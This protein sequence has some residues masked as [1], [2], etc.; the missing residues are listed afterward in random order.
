MS[1]EYVTDELIC[2]IIG[3]IPHD[4]VILQVDGRIYS[5][6]ALI[7]WLNNNNTSPY[8]RKPC[9]IADIIKSPVLTNICAAIH[10]DTNNVVSTTNVDDTGPPHVTSHITSCGPVSLTVPGYRNDQLL[11]KLECT[12]NNNIVVGTKSLEWSDIILCIDNSYSTGNRVETH[13]PITGVAIESGYTINDLIRHTAKAVLASLENTGSRVGVI[14]FDDCVEEITHLTEVT[15]SNKNI[16]LAKIDEIAPRG[17]TNIWK[18][19]REAAK[20]LMTRN[21]NS[22][23]PAILLLTDGQPSHGTNRPENEAISNLFSSPPHEWNCE[24][25]GTIPVYSMGFGYS[26][27]HGL[28]YKIARDTGGVNTSIPGPEMMVTAF[29]S[30]LANILNT[31]CFSTKIHIVLHD[32]SLWNIGNNS[33]IIDA[34]LPIKY[35]YHDDNTVHIEILIGSLQFEQTRDIVLNIEPRSN[36]AIATLNASFYEGGTLSKT[37]NITICANDLL[38][39]TLN[40]EFEYHFLRNAACLSL[41]YMAEARERG[42]YHLCADHYERILALCALTPGES[43]YKLRLTWEDQVKMAA[44]YDTD[45]CCNHWNK[46]GWIYVDQ[47]RSALANQCSTNFKDEALLP[48]VTPIV[49]ETS[50][51]VSNIFDDLPP[52]EPTYQFTR[53]SNNSVHTTP[54]QHIYNMSSFN[55]CSA[56]TV[57][58]TECTK[59]S[60]TRKGQCSAEIISIGAILP[61]DRV[62]GSILDTSGDFKSYGYFSVEAIVSTKCDHEKVDLVEVAPNCFSTPWHPVKINGNKWTSA[63][64]I[65]KIVTK[66]ASRVVSLV[67]ENGAAI[68]LIPSISSSISCYG[69]SLGHKCSAPGIAHPFWGTNAVLK[70]IRKL[71]D[72]PIITITSNMIERQ[73]TKYE[74]G[75]EVS[76]I[77]TTSIKN[78]T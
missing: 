18:G 8:T 47:L 10:K 17:S 70:A 4:P 53:V 25:C 55:Q 5:K 15:K 45:E 69:A 24:P 37:N 61:G 12:K 62:L 36:E 46:W 31:R 22:K 1:H 21:D 54:Q 78:I 20:I 34:D 72:Y 6:K 65:N 28:M 67:V 3:E 42:Q 43:A 73:G 50:D 33:V 44:A 26:L 60:A 57:C 32:K 52:T 2:P 9:T 74:W 27:K 30:A 40:P 41:K 19:C 58:F 75:R 16:L 77:I 29:G 66:S 23:N 7:T 39:I 13:D 64:N 59:V 68:R 11:L 63:S 49:G 56:S 48:F 35:E 51:R 38:D 76:D 71:P 14:T